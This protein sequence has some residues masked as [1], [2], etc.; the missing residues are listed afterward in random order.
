MKELHVHEITGHSLV[1]AKD[2]PALLDENHIEFQTIDCV[3]WNAYPYR[4][5]VE[6]RMAHTGEAILLNYRVKEESIR[7]VAAEDNGRVWEDSCCE[8]FFQLPEDQE[9]N[10]YYNFEC[11]CGG[12]LLIGGGRPGDRPH[13]PL[14]IT[15]KV[16]RWTSLD[17]APFEERMGECSW[18]LALCIPKEAFFRH[19]L[20][21]FKG[22]T[23]RAN[24]YKCGDLQHTPHFLSWNKIDLPEPCF[25]CPEFFGKILF[26]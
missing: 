6:F 18:Q 24:F 7:A 25:H 21:G 1:P 15:R 12:T 8:F 20:K 14:E 17:K 22:M 4:P 10:I 3:N 9:E 19:Q 16:D 5:E 26:E 13:A 2:I 11:N 23:A